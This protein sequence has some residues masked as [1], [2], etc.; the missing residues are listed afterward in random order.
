MAIPVYFG[1]AS[2]EDS[3]TNDVFP[4]LPLGYVADT[5]FVCLCTNDGGVAIPTPTG[6]SLTWTQVQG[7]P[8]TAV[9]AAGTSVQLALF[10]A[11][12]A[13]AAETPPTVSRNGGNHIQARMIGINGCRAGDPIHKTSADTLTADSTAFTIP[14]LTTT[15]DE[16]LLLFFVTRGTDVNVATGGFVEGSQ[17][18]GGLDTGT[19][20]PVSRLNYGTTLGNGS[21]LWFLTGAKNGA[22][23]IGPTTGTIL[24]ASAQA[25]ML[26]A[27]SS[28]AEPGGGGGGSAATGLRSLLNPGLN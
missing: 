11:R 9:S 7:S 2:N 15:L 4:V 17:L 25:R 6:G 18:N 23:I 22:G 28:F 10:W 3:A 12:A 24:L 19:T 14:G 20:H 27:L 8:Q 16:C 13:S 1:S 21:G 5:V 26:V